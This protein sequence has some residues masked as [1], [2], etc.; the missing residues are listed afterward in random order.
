MP[1]LESTLHKI[2]LIL[3]AL[4]LLIAGKSSFAQNSSRYSSSSVLSKGKWVKVEVTETGI[5]YI[6]NTTLRAMGFSA[7]EK[8]NVYGYGG[9]VI[10]ENLNSPDDLPMLPA[11]NT[12]LG[13]IFFGKASV[14]WELN[15]EGNTLYRHMSHP[16]SDKSYYFLSDDSEESKSVKSISIPGEAKDT[17]SEFKERLV[18]EQDLFMPMTSGRLILGEDFR[19]VTSRNFKFDLPGNSGGVKI[20]TAFGC[21]TSSGIPT[22]VFTANGKQLNATTS[23]RLPYT[24]SKLVVTTKT[25]KEIA[26]TD[27]FLDLNIKFN[28]SGNVSFAGLDYIEVEY[29][30]KLKIKGE[31]LYFYLCPKETS[32]VRVE[33]AE[34][35]T[36]IWDVTEACF[37]RLVE[38]I[39]NGKE[40]IFKSEAGYHEYIAF[41]PTSLKNSINNYESTINQD[42]HSLPAPDMVVIAP[43]EYHTAAQRLVNL[44]KKTDGLQLLVL[45]P[46]EIYNEFSCG[47]PDVSAFRKMLK[48][49]YD[50]AGGREG[51]Y[52]LYCLI[53]SRPTYDNKSVSSQVRN[54]GY[55]R[56]PIWQSPTGDSESTSY[57][58]DDY[59]GMLE[60]VEGNFNIATATINVAVGRMPFKNI[61]EATRMMDKLEAY[62][63]NPEYGSWRNSV[64]VI[65]DD[66]DRGVHIEQAESVIETMKREGKGKDVVYEKLYLDSYPLEYTGVG[67]SYPLARER[68]M[69]RWNDGLA[70][71]NY[72]G[73]ANSK[74]WG[75]EGL[76]TWKDITSMKNKH[77]PFLYAATCDFLRWDE[78]EISGGEAL[79]LLPNSGIIG[80][81]CP[82]REVV[83]STNGIINKIT[84]KYIFKND[85]NGLPLSMGEIMRRGKNESNSGTNK[86]RY[87]YLGDPSLRLPWNNNFIKIEQINGTAVN[88][89]EEMPELTARSNV[90]L[91]GCIEDGEGKIIENFNG[92]F[93]VV[94]YDAEKTITT[95]GNGKDGVEMVYNDRKTKLFTGKTKVTAGKWEIDF[96]MPGEI[97]NNFSPALFSMYGFDEEGRE[98]TGSYSDFYVYGY[99]E[100]SPEDYEGPKI[101]EFY[102]N[103]PN[104]I[105]GSE[106]SPDPILYAKFYDESGIN[107]S[108]SGIGH[109]MIIEIDGNT[110]R[111]DLAHYYQ[112]DEENPKGG[113]L[114]Y[115]LKDIGYGNHT[116]KFIVWDNANNSSSA[117]MEFKLSALWKPTIEILTTDVNPANSSVNFIIETDGS[118]SV[119]DCSI[120][121]YDLTG[122]KVWQDKAPALT[123][124]NLRTLLNWNLCDFGGSR[125]PGG[126]YL[127]RALVR[128]EGGIEVTKSNKLIVR[129]Q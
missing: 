101:L 82:S 77:L 34:E 129:T 125:I 83:I 57:S 117:T 36:V 119:M 88:Q 16:Y 48:M 51:G 1:N 89:E 42:I 116:L 33:N 2:G 93:E 54:C 28:G 110:Y 66:Q 71:I 74:S 64:M 122:R 96:M 31:Q 15:T 112:P 39:R 72:I 13:L 69:K 86:L 124:E 55:P 10:P 21:K 91:I 121:V 85:R 118:T 81:I 46:E 120:E 65:A 29:T 4:F 44:H 41:N 79:W 22:L 84:S 49:W 40:I 104:F 105:N 63:M 7:P 3:S 9:C 95:N 45:T 25:I 30:R 111:D 106:V 61:E 17:L 38:C 126:L 8:V 128:T 102:L 5:Q 59:I 14:D 47:K 78:D 99:D 19:S 70:F 35:E 103:H 67:A 27:E 20:T 60:D 115:A 114:K 37:P 53:M 26:I 80:M 43:Q 24:E 6:D 109:N 107:V 92:I 90:N 97:E 11:I 32:Y 18:H 12:E 52:P 62:L 75:H 108:E 100:N 113:K 87:G 58:T 23:D 50:R 73:H 98:A 56:V 127:Y 68:M 76:L 94:L 123:G